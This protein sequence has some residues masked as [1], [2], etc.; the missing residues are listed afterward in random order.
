[1]HSRTDICVSKRPVDVSGFLD[2]SNTISDDDT[3]RPTPC[4]LLNFVRSSWEICYLGNRIDGQ[5]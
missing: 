4:P 5:R 3:S 1:M 2:I